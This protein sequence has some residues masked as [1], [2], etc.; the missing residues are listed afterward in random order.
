MCP[1][2]IGMAS[3]RTVPAM[4]M[5]LLLSPSVP[6]YQ[7][8]A[9]YMTFRSRT[10]RYFLSLPSYGDDRLISMIFRAHTGITV[11]SGTNT[12]TGCVEP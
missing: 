3:S 11:T 9:F 4:T 8:K 2:S 6:L 5:A 12:V 10:N 7:R 1:N